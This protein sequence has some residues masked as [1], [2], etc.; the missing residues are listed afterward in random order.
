MIKLPALKVDCPCFIPQ[1]KGC[2]LV[3]QA[4]EVISE[5]FCKVICRN[6]TNANLPQILFNQK[7]DVNLDNGK[8]KAG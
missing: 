1:A 4:V 6:T 8:T 3:T 2:Q 7:K 5:G